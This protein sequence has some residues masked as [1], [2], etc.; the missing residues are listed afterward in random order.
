MSTKSEINRVNTITL[1]LIKTWKKTDGQVEN[2]STQLQFKQPGKYRG[3]DSDG[4]LVIKDEERGRTLIVQPDQKE[5]VLHD[6][7]KR[8]HGN[9]NLATFV[10]EYETLECKDLGEQELEGRMVH[11]Y[12]YLYDN[13]SRAKTTWWVDIQSNLPI[14]IVK[15]RTDRNPMDPETH[16]D[17]TIIMRDI[18]FNAELDDRLFEMTVP[19]G[20]KLRV[21]RNKW[22]LSKKTKRE[23]EDLVLALRLYAEDHDGQFPPEFLREVILDSGKMPPSLPEEKQARITMIVDGFEFVKMLYCSK[24]DWHYEGQGVRLGQAE[25]IIF[26][27]GHPETEIYRV[28]FGDLSVREMSRKDLPSSGT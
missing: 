27:Y 1:N 11:G 9:F 6:D 18:V 24:I 12:R 14:I 26:W 3:V 20:C 8:H 23:E 13:V 5:A 28:I 2:T 21:K 10:L 17:Y 25:K 15:G 16:G 22:V 7:D 19:K 4:T